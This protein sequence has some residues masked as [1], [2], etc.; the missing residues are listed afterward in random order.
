M[1]KIII[2][3][4]DDTGAAMA[5]PEA[6]LSMNAG[7]GLTAIDSLAGVSRAGFHSTEIGADPGELADIEKIAGLGLSGLKKALRENEVKTF[8]VR[9]AVEV[10]KVNLSGSAELKDRIKKLIDLAHTL[11]AENITVKGGSL[12]ESPEAERYALDLIY[13]LESNL[14]ESGV[15]I[16]FASFGDTGCFINNTGS[17]NN[18]V[19]N[20]PDSAGLHIADGDIN[21]EVIRAGLADCSAKINVAGVSAMKDIEKNI[22]LSNQENASCLLRTL[23]KNSFT[24]GIMVNPV[25]KNPDQ[26]ILTELYKKMHNFILEVIL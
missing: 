18:F 5:V 4:E 24:G 15:N 7:N 3:G 21:S 19:R 23:A 11:D 13:S 17:L 8:S 16:S 10:G 2:P 22:A 26:R 20:I 1:V 14:Q 25:L 12:N 9:S 6:M